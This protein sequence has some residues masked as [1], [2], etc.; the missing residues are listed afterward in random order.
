[1][2]SMILQKDHYTQLP[3]LSFSLAIENSVGDTKYCDRATTAV[4][5]RQTSPWSSWVDIGFQWNI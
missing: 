1:M 4:P 2:Y 3:Q 5:R